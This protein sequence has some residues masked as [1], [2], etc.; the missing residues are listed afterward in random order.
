MGAGVGVT[1]TYGATLEL[2]RR[3]WNKYVAQ[4]IEDDFN[5]LQDSLQEYRYSKDSLK[6]KQELLDR[7]FKD[8]LKEHGRDAD[9]GWFDRLRD[10]SVG[11]YRGRVQQTREA[12]REALRRY[13]LSSTR[14]SPDSFKDVFK[15]HPVA[16]I[17]SMIQGS[18]VFPK[19]FLAGALGGAAAG[20]GLG[21][22][23]LKKL[24]DREK[25]GSAMWFDQGYTDT[26]VK[27]GY[28]EFQGQYDYGPDP[29]ATAGLG[30]LG[31]GV[32]GA[33]GVG[34]GVHSAAKR[35]AQSPAWQSSGRYAVKGVAANPRYTSAVRKMTMSRL[36][37]R[38]L[39]G[40][41]IGALAGT[42]LG[43]LATKNTGE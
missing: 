35:L 43:L 38:G 21:Y 27:L 23:G 41:G 32:G 42:G 15:A 4:R 20:A 28:D 7:T 25:K 2:K 10:R 26:L 3:E 9:L 34:L 33:A 24:R 37:K 19:R 12:V 36:G 39:M 11:G 30:V 22:Y 18:R 13:R 6:H 8:L 14:L 31:A 40:L 5:K 1:G 17:E 29:R 16:H